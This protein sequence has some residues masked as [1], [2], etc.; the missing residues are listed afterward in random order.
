MAAQ[1]L[2]PIVFTTCTPH[3]VTVAQ[4]QSALRRLFLGDAFRR[5]LLSS[6]VISRTREYRYQV[7]IAKGGYKD[8]WHLRKRCIGRGGQVGSRFHRTVVSAD[9]K[10]L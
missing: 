8:A 10:Y 4:W 3:R 7:M 1:L 9:A 6:I 2:S 5:K